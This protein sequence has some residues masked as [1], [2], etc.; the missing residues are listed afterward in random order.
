MIQKK[1]KYFTFNQ[2][3]L[4]STLINCTSQFVK[5][6]RTIQKKTIGRIN[7]QLRKKRIKKANIKFVLLIEKFIFN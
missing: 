1:C 6:T 7:K 2:F 3:H 5:H 4:S